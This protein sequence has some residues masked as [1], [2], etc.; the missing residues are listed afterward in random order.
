[1]C[2]CLYRWIKFEIR[3]SNFRFDLDFYLRIKIKISGLFFLRS[4]FSDAD[5]CSQIWI[6]RKT[7]VRTDEPIL[8]AQYVRFGTSRFWCKDQIKWF[9]DPI[10][11]HTGKGYN[12]QLDGGTELVD[13]EKIELEYWK[14]S[15]L[16]NEVLGKN[17]IDRT[18]KQWLK[19]FVF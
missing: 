14:E 11:H 5:P 8:K 18:K 12:R 4:F 7:R 13:F 19:Y 9:C 3:F 17:W 15:K 16:R 1:M 10:L 2:V 6:P